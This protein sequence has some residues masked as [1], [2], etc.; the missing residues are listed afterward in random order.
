MSRKKT[1]I[2]IFIALF[3]I[4]LIYI[5]SYVFYF[6]VTYIHEITTK[7]EAY[8]FTIGDNKL[9][10]YKKIPRLRQ[11]LNIRN[12]RIFIKIEVDKSNST[13]LGTK[14]KFDVLTESLFHEVGFPAFNKK[15]KWSL[16]FNGMYH[17]SLDLE[18]C[19][20]I[21]CEIHRHRQYF[22]FP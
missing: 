18:F 21:L 12:Q 13:L 1:F 19:D 3:L 10:T 16:Y 4:P 2:I 5:T 6:W 7:G 9:Q 14:P 8:G 17:D 20:N 11:Y 15:D 22:E